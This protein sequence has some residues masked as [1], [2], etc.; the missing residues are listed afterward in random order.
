MISTGHLWVTLLLIG[1]L[2]L[3]PIGAIILLRQWVKGKVRYY[4][5]L[6]FIFAF[7][8]IIMCIYTPIELYFVAFYPAVSIESP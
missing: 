2:I 3:Y 8:L 7:V 4:T 5:D 1:R 6:P